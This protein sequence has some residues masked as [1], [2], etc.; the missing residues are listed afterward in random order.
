MNPPRATFIESISEAHY[1]AL[2]RC[3]LLTG[4]VDDLFPVSLDGVPQ[5][6]SLE[7]ALDVTFAHARYPKRGG[8]DRF[9][10]INVMADGIRFSSPEDIEE[11][12][13]L[14]SQ[15]PP[16]GGD[17][18]L[19]SA[20]EAVERVLAALDSPLTS[21]QAVV[22][23]GDFLRG[24]AL[25]RTRSIPVRPLVIVVHHAEALWPNRDVASLGREDRDLLTYLCDLLSDEQI[26]ADG[27]TAETRPD[28]ILLLSPT[29]SEVSR[30]VQSL[31]R[32][33]H[34]EVGLPDES[35]REA[36]ARARIEQRPVMFDPLWAED[37]L[38]AL[39]QDARGLTLRAL[40]DVLTSAHRT[41]TPA[42]RRSVLQQVNSEL[43][44]K[45]GSIVNVVYPG[46]NLG[47][48]VGNRKLKARL[49]QLK[50]R[51]D[52]PER[53]PAG[54][55]VVGSN[56]SGKTYICEAF[57]AE[58]GR[59]VVTLSQIRS[60]WF[61]QTDAFAEMFESTLSVF[62]RILIMV[63][64]AHVAFGSIHDPQTHETEARLTGHII[65]MMDN[66]RNRGNI[67][68]ALMTTRPDLLDPDVV[69][70]GR[71]SL[72]VPVFD[73]EG[74]DAEDFLAWLLS[75][76]RKESIELDEDDV[77]RLR[78]GTHAFSAGDYREFIGDFIEEMEFNPQTTLKEFL[79][80]WVPSA[81][82]LAEERELQML[83]AALRCDWRELLP[84]D[85]R[86]LSRDEIQARVDHLRTALRR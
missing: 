46:H 78:A 79:T 24:V 74:E 7:R 19:Q 73:P 65:Q 26:W 21:A 1:A 34:I 64:E 3:V 39:V 66:E 62:G 10:V 51:I 15:I 67:L 40:D 18:K 77:E 4:N 35:L 54:M 30:R 50:R 86:T 16:A 45:L 83:L 38:R 82:S 76:F 53:A 28:F 20:G 25:L 23:L 85:L 42:S 81:V 49:H 22:A 59:V 44:T 33:V 14:R 2:C 32:T 37:P 31:P 11:L 36:F 13:K 56:G 29:A 9:L 8:T 41:G 17:P 27:D 68:W 69:R 80:S 6:V 75:S 61:G 57:A 47:N 55:T 12:Q 63:D 84:E 52:D 60:Q 5:F 48:I 72:F 58:T 43:K 71:C 70:R